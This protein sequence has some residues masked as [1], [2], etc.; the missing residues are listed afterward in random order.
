M[1]SLATHEP[2]F[3]I[4]REDVFAQGAK[5]GCHKCGQPGHH[6]SNC[7]GL[8]EADKQK[9]LEEQKNAPL[10][11]FIFLDVS[12]LREYLQVELNV[13]GVPFFDLE[14]AIDDWVFMI[15]FV[16]NDFLP[17]LPSLDI[18]EGAI[19]MLLKIW[20]DALPTMGGYLTNSG[21][22]ELARAQVI[23]DG[24]ASREDEI[25]R[26][27][28]EQEQRQEENDKEKRRRI[29]FSKRGL[30]S[31]EKPGPP[32]GAEIQSSGID[33]VPV[34]KETKQ[35]QN[36]NA[37]PADAS[38]AVKPAFVPASAIPST[39]SPT[40]SLPA[41]GGPPKPKNPMFLSSRASGTAPIRN[42]F[43]LGGGRVA[44]SKSASA[45]GS[46]PSLMGTSKDVVM[47]RA[48]IR[49][50][51]LSAA[52]MLKAELAGKAKPESSVEDTK[53]AAA[54]TAGQEEV[55]G[56]ASA[57]GVA[58][59][60]Q[61]PIEESKTAAAETAGEQEMDGA[62][63]APAAVPDAET[64]STALPDAAAA[65]PAEGDAMI[66]IEQPTVAVEQDGIVDAIV[67]TPAVVAENVEEDVP[68]SAVNGEGVA[69][70]AVEATE[71]VS[72]PASSPSK[73]KKRTADEAG[74]PAS[75][76]QAEIAEIKEEEGSSSSSDEDD[77]EEDDDGAAD[78][79][80][81]SVS[82]P[83]PKPLKMLGGNM[84]EQEDTVQ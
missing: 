23:M 64:G 48:A 33:Y 1:L 55:D 22:V 63:P 26:K 47:N 61:V 65:A 4:L 20:R 51:N 29:E 46:A 2:N 7:Q 16:G 24:L 17:H 38:E 62:S 27:R 39:V 73:G 31:E 60:T 11:P 78:V 72:E 13:P 76:T 6:S 8:S 50:A 66:E 40:Q 28:R 42:N 74:I 15:F 57:P 82:M 75:R 53:P 69:M 49:Q 34:L 70:A 71:A 79:T 52:E 58:S 80:T 56:V 36:G 43:G 19:D 30:G 77:A 10:K 5:R 59:D 44:P 12:I 35:Y 84:V 18:R 37:T 67:N 41:P 25:F 32:P 54:E 68:A 45:D 14:R 21:R 83:V 9:Q 81:L 3:K